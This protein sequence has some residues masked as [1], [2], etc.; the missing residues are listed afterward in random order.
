M[1]KTLISDF[2]FMPFFLS[3]QI[4]SSIISTFVYMLGFYANPAFV[5]SCY[6]GLLELSK[7][8]SICLLIFLQIFDIKTTCFQAKGVNLSCVRACVVVAE[9]RPR[10]QLTTSFTKLF[11]SLGLAPRAVST[12]FGCRVNVGI[13]LQVI[14]QGFFLVRRKSRKKIQK[15]FV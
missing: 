7:I 3:W 6:S 14:M 5:S 12:S 2:K 11:A 10:I 13:C 8:E 1:F 15:I 4:W 9:E